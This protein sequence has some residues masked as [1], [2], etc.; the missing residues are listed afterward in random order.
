MARDLAPRQ[1]IHIYSGAQQAV[2]L[3]DI[4]VPFSEIKRTE[5]EADNTS[6]IEFSER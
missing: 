5:R 1:S 6:Y 2:F 3:M 4:G